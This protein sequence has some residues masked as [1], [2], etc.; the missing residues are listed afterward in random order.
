M[1][2]AMNERARQK[3]ALAKLRQLGKGIW[4]FH[5]IVIGHDEEFIMYQ[6][7]DVGQ[8]LAAWGTKIA[9]ARALGCAHSLVELKEVKKEAP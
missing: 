6:R 5:Y 4:V 7:G 9:L 1:L 3:R 2:A 8:K